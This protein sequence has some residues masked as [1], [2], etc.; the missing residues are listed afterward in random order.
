MFENHFF[1]ELFLQA[2]MARDNNEVPIGAIIVDK[3]KRI[4]AQSY[5]QVEKLKDPTAHAEI[6]C[7]KEACKKLDTKYLFDCSI[8]VTIEP[9]FMCAA[10][11]SFAKIAKVYFSGFE[12]KTGAIESNLH[13][14]SQKYC[15]HKPEI[16]GGIREK[17]AVKLMQDFFCHK[18]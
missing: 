6:L 17:E 1:D 3:N 2:K 16:Y 14:F 7:I 18:R 12:P 15:H 5:N 10:A 8:Y 11:I 9:C 4:I 13:Y